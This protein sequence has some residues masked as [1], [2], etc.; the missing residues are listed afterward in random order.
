MLQLGDVVAKDVQAVVY[1]Q[2][3]GSQAVYF[4]AVDWWNAPENIRKAQL[5]INGSHYEV[6]LPFGVMKKA[7]AKD[8]TAI[9]CQS[10]SADVLRFTDT[11]AVV[12]GEG[13]EEFLIF[14]NGKTTCVSVD[15]AD[16][17]QKEITF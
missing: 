4:I 7:L 15:F 10:E 8:G 2:P 5:R 1:D 11:G 9:L 14:Q 16:I 12:Q 6:S 17:P 13:V 3:D